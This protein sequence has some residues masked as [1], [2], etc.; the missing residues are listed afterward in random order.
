MFTPRAPFSRAGSVARALK[1]LSRFPETG[2]LV[3]AIYKSGHA[4]LVGLAIIAAHIYFFAHLVFVA[5]RGAVDAS[6]APTCAAHAAHATPRTPHTP[7]SPRSPLR[8]RHTR[9]RGERI[10][11]GQCTALLRNDNEPCSFVCAWWWQRARSVRDASTDTGALHVT[12]H[13]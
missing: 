13:A 2:L 10:A 1:A 6:G 11:R 12:A 4:L 7:R 3:D 8:C 5:E 9:A